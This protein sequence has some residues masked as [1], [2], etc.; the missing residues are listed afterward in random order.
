MKLNTLAIGS[1]LL[2]SACASAPQPTLQE[3]IAG[4]SETER[5]AILKEEC[6]KEASWKNYGGRPSYSSS[7]AHVRRM[8]EICETM[9][10]EI[11]TS[12]KK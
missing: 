9:S 4:K 7:N 10:G 2:L 5:T 8:K 12:V 6:L 3:K 1:V 11:V